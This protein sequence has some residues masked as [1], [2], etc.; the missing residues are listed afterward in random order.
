MHAEHLVGTTPHDPHCRIVERREMPQAVGRVDDVVSRL[1]KTSVAL[2]ACPQLVLG[3][4][5]CLHALCNLTQARA[6][7]DLCHDLAGQS[8]QRP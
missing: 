7:L 4:L 8:A 3:L 1:D 5:T 6:L 2:L